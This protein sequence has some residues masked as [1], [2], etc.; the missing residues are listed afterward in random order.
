MTLD[1]SGW[2]Q[3]EELEFEGNSHKKN[4]VKKYVPYIKS[5][6]NKTGI[7]KYF[8]EYDIRYEFLNCG[9]LCKTA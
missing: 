4:N 8:S 2:K 3:V 1:L 5:S 6:K 7:L 9:K